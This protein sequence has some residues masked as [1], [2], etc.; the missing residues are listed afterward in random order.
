MQEQRPSRPRVW[1]VFFPHA[2]LCGPLES[3][4]TGPSSDPQKQEGRAGAIPRT[5]HSVQSLRPPLALCLRT[6]LHHSRPGVLESR[7]KQRHGDLRAPPSAAFLQGQ[8]QRAAHPP[9]AEALSSRGSAPCNWP[10]VQCGGR[11]HHLPT[12]TRPGGEL[13]KPSGVSSGACERQQ[14]APQL[15]SLQSCMHGAIYFLIPFFK[16]NIDFL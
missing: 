10:V 1:S 11:H 7:E 9:S 14:P 6:D 2:F 5:Y 13:H 8:A 4:V 15:S 12:Q 16:K 3:D